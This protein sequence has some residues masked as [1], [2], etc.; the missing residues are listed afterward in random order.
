VL[1]GVVNYELLVTEFLKTLMLKDVACGV[2]LAW[3]ENYAN[4]YCKL[5]E[6]VYWKR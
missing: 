4:Y 5:L 2:G 6:K 1:G 3:G